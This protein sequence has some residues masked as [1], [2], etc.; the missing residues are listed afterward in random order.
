M[1]RRKQSRKNNNST[2]KKALALAKKANQ[3][4]LK[5]V[6]LAPSAR[7]ILS[8]GESITSN[9]WIISQGTDTNN[10]VGNVIHSTRLKIQGTLSLNASATSSFMRVLIYKY[11]HE[12]A[13]AVTDIL[14]SASYLSQ[15][16]IEHRYDS[17]VLFDRTYNVDSDKPKRMININLKTGFNMYYGSADASDI[18]KNGLFILMIGDEV[19]NVP[20]FTRA[21]THYYHE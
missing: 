9:Q 15:K 10:R 18:E 21:I 7:T 5:Y 13:S 3:K 11:S 20:T 6:Q 2:A 17:K 12:L 4:E 14:E 16:S 8:A 1:A 19:T